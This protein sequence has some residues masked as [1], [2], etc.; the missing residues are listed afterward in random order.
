MENEEG[1]WLEYGWQTYEEAYE[2]FRG[3]V[4]HLLRKG[5]LPGKPIEPEDWDDILSWLSEGD[6]VLAVK[7]ESPDF[8][9]MYFTLHGTFDGTDQSEVGFAAV[10]DEGETYPFDIGVCLLGK[11][12]RVYQAPPPGWPQWRGPSK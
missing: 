10:D 4:N 6:P 9:T 7:G 3:L 5:F 8:S 11:Q 12:R 2:N 1:R